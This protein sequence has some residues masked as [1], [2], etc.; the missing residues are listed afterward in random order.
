[1]VGISK[2]EDDGAS[3]LVS[4]GPVRQ[5]ATRTG[6]TNCRLAD[7]LSGAVRARCGGVHGRQCDFSGILLRPVSGCFYNPFS[8]AP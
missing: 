4:H 2:A 8:E 7:V 1:M 6:R 5:E 3:Y